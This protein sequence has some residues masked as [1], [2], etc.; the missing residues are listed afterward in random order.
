MFANKLT[1]KEFV[2]TKSTGDYGNLKPSAVFID[3]KNKMKAQLGQYKVPALTD[4]IKLAENI[5]TQDQIDDWYLSKLPAHIQLLEKIKRRGQIKNEG[6]RLEYVITKTN[7]LK[8]KQANKIESFDYFLKH[9][10]IL[11]LDYLYYMEQL[12]NPVD[13]VLNVVFGR[14]GFIKKRYLEC[15]KRAKQLESMYSRFDFPTRKLYLVEDS[16]LLYSFLDHAGAE[17]VV[18]AFD[19]PDG[20]D[21]LNA[22]RKKYG[23]Q[24]SLKTKF[25]FYINNTFSKRNSSEKTLLNAIRKI[26]V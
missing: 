16:N 23:P 6:S 14:P 2:M 24:S 3:D 7:N 17:R 12:I 15:V 5:S 1:L 18:C 10:D 22:L 25:E 19:V 13:Q 20:L 11:E 4:E 26:L 21:V 8:D 9:T